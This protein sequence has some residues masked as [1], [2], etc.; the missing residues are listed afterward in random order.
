MKIKITAPDGY[1]LLDTKTRQ[2]HSEVITDEK[3][4]SRYVLVPKSD[5]ST[6]EIIGG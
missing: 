6:I 1:K 4:K 2:T 3:N 5:E